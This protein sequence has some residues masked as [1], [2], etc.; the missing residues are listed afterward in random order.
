LGAPKN[1]DLN[2]F[3]NVKKVSDVLKVCSKDGLF[4]IKSNTV[5]T[6]NTVAL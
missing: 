2:M 5:E 6:L 4:P 3:H 1:V